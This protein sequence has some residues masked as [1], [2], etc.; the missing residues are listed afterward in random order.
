MGKS[1]ISAFHARFAGLAVVAVTGHN[2]DHF[3][4]KPLVQPQVLKRPHSVKDG[5]AVD[6]TENVALPFE[7]V[8][9]GKGQRSIPFH[10]G[11][12]GNVAVSFQQ[13]NGCGNL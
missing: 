13:F 10:M 9:P 12:N 2:I 11:Q 4:S 3:V 5:A 6:L 7:A 8:Q 1:G